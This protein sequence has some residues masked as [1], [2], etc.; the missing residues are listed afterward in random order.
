M[1]DSNHYG[2]D[3]QGSNQYKYSYGSGSGRGTT[4]PGG[5]KSP[6]KNDDVG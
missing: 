3:S 4:P 5:Q 6:K 2:P 1:S